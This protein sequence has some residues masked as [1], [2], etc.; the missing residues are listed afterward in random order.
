[1]SKVLSGLDSY[2]DD[3]V[4]VTGSTYDDAGIY[5]VNDEVALVQTVDFFTP[6]VDDPYDF[7]RVAVANSLS[8]VYAMGGVPKTA[9]NV[10]T[11]PINCLDSSILKEILRG[12]A[13]KLV[14]AGVALLGGHTVED[15]EPKYGVS[16][17][18]FVHPDQ[19]W[20]NGG[21]RPGDVLVLTKKLG[22]GLVTTA[23][24]GDL[25][26]VAPGEI[27]E[28]TES[29]AKLNRLAAETARSVGGV[30]ACTDITGFGL[31]GH[32]LE[33]V[34]APGGGLTFEVDSG[35]LPFLERALAY[36]REGLIPAGAYR[37]RDYV[38]DRVLYLVPEFMELAVATP[39]T[40]GGLVLAFDPEGGREYVRR[41]EALGEPAWIIGKVKGWEE[42]D[43]IVY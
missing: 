3:N 25:D 12:G 28:V 4:L 32:L 34:G 19:I 31:V 9:M 41:M 2:T 7:G 13:D 5:R 10:V 22:V 42:K 27:V 15:S 40:S 16:V 6:M 43:L 11:F 39:E 33:M 30:H 20:T 26:A 29:M 35:K 38:K 23:I 24:K 14:E 8:D 1:M 37:N 21:A 36:A 18:G 17:T